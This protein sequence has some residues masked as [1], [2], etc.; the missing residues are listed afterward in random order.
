MA[1]YD[2]SDIFYVVTVE[3]KDRSFKEFM[4]FDRDT[5]I[6]S[7][8]KKLSKA[9]HFESKKSFRKFEEWCNKKWNAT[10]SV[11]KVDGNEATKKMSIRINLLC[12]KSE[13]TK[14][15]FIYE[16]R[17]KFRI[18]KICQALQVSRSSYYALI[19][20]PLSLRQRR[21]DELLAGIKD[22]F[23]KN[24]RIYYST[25]RVAAALPKEQNA[26]MGSF[27]EL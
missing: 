18:A 13:V 16:H 1:D 14:F 26:P 10:F 8:T 21:R 6:V 7:P 15:K 4:R 19:K 17:S 27:W 11:V 22:I 9:T 2:E 24:H 20:R 12:E 3:E 23:Y 25:L 5:G